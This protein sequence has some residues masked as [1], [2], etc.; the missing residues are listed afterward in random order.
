MNTALLA[1]A[2]SQHSEGGGILANLIV[3]AIAV[4]IIVAM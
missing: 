1:Q 3:L 2:T 4:L